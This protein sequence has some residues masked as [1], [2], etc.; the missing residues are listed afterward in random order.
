MIMAFMDLSAVLLSYLAFECNDEWSDFTLSY[1]R[2]CQNDP[3]QLQQTFNTAFIL[4]IGIAI[5]VL[6][7]L[8]RSDFGCY[9][10][11]EHSR[12]EN[13]CSCLGVSIFNNFLNGQHHSSSIQCDS[14]FA[15][16]MDVYAIVEIVGSL[17]K[18]LIATLL[19]I[20]VCDKLIYMEDLC[21]YLHSWLQWH[22]A[23]IALGIMTNAGLIGNGIRLSAVL[24]LAFRMES[25]F[26]YLL[27][28]S[29]T[30][31]KYVA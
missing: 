21:S 9:S 6:F 11:I 10:K 14:Y 17:L 8:K 28:Y 7:W 3:R 19:L 16:K 13:E 23:F 4:H 20:T 31:N 24:C 2:T 25:L 15:R 30:G 29:S 22:I 12:W 1:S 5:I 18:L 27:Y 26:Q